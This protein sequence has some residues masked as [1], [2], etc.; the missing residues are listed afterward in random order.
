MN[1][2]D[3]PLDDIDAA[4]ACWRQGDLALGEQWLLTRAD[5][6]RPL[7]PESRSMCEKETG[8]TEVEVP[9]LAV[10]TQTCDLV[11]RW[12]ERPYVEVAPLVTLEERVWPLARRG[13]LPRYFVLRGLETRCLAVDLDR[14]MTFEKAVVAGWVRVPGCADD[15][16]ARRFALALGRK[17]ARFAFPEDLVKLVRELQARLIQKHD[18]ASPEGRALQ[19]LREIRL[20]ASPSWD[21]DAVEL[22]FTFLREQGERDF[23]G[24]AWEEWREAW[25]GLVQP[26]G[27]FRQVHGLVQTLDDL[28]ARDYVESD[29]LDLNFLSTRAAEP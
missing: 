2:S 7:T 28:T 8:N 9:G 14:V 29:P 16:E 24:V 12:T 27:R 4:L 6:A 19:A 26:V 1:P 20:R 17:R 22:T 11:R 3:R 10:L 23:E 18:K 13:R 25:L 5:P 21:A 15:E